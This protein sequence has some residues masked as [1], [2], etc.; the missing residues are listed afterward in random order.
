MNLA[1]KCSFLLIIASVMVVFIQNQAYCR[2]LANFKRIPLIRQMRKG[3]QHELEYE[4]RAH[5]EGFFSDDDIPFHHLDHLPEWN[6]LPVERMQNQ[7]AEFKKPEASTQFTPR[8]YQ[9]QVNESTNK[10]LAQINS[11]SPSS[12]MSTF[13]VDKSIPKLISITTR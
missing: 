13:P 8:V 11:T 9:T 3:L 12:I 2:L 10:S 6:R 5:H 1:P 7:Q 4:V